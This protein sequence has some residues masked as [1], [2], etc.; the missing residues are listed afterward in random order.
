MFEQIYDTFRKATESSFQMQQD[1]LKQWMSGWPNPMQNIGGGAV[2]SASMLE[3]QV[4]AY[5]KQWLETF[6]NSLNKHREALDAQYKSGIQAIESAFRTSE[7]KSPEEYRRLT[8]EFWRKSFESLKSAFEN[9]FKDFQGLVEKWFE[10][11]TK[12]KV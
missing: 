7:A 6:T 1:M 8:E 5:Q 11:A 9:Q 12:V 2:P 4:K 10:M 3:D